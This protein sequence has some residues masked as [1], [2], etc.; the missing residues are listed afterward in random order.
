[1][2]IDWITMVALVLSVLLL[3]HLLLSLLFAERL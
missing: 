1:M 2:Q 3:V